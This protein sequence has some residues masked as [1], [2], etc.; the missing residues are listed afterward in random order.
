MAGNYSRD[1]LELLLSNVARGYV[2]LR[3]EQGVPVLDRDL[4]LLGE[5]ITAAVRRVFSRYIG[6]GV[7]SDDN[8]FAIEAIP[9][10]NDFVIRAPTSGEGHFLVGGLE[11]SIDAD[12]NYTD[13]PEFEGLAPELSPPNAAAGER[14]DTIYLD[15]WLEEIDTD[16][17]PTVDLGNL[18][19]VGMRTSVRLL[20]SWVVRVREGELEPPQDGDPDYDDGHVYTALAT[21]TRPVDDAEIANVQIADQ[22]QTQL[23]LA[24]VE[25]RLSLVEEVTIEPSF[26]PDDPFNVGSQFVGEPLTLQGSHFALEP[27]TVTIG[28]MDATLT[29][30]PTESAVEVIVPALLGEGDDPIEVSVTLTTRAG[31]AEAPELLAVLAPVA[32]EPEPEPEP[33]DL[34]TFAVPP[35]DTGSAFRGADI[36]LTGTNFGEDI[37]AVLFHEVAGEDFGS[38]TG[39]VAVGIVDPGDWSDTQITVEVPDMADRPRVVFIT[40]INGDDAMV[41]STDTFN[42]LG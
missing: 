2:G 39:D 7:A 25:Q 24:D 9:A 28:G 18:G 26:D 22:R 35:W 19:D 10:D 23:N 3:V 11:V 31:T 27:V 16:T 34:P 14:I 15:A 38:P 5:L 37:G 4:N 29:G 21:L 1:P 20:P 17:D 41:T 32:E 40:V 12:V 42:L 8:A 13:Q 6:D 36:T 33:A 30:P